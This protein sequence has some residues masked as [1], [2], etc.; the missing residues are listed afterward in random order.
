MMYLHD[1]LLYMPIKHTTIG[2]L[3]LMHSHLCMDPAET[4]SEESKQHLLSAHSQVGDV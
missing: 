1:T 2:G 3:V 4:E